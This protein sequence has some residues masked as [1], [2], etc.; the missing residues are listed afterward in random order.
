MSLIAK[1]FGSSK[2]KKAPSPQEAIQ[3]LREI[4]EMLNKKNEYLEKK[5][6]EELHT[7]KKNAAKNKRVAIQ[8]LKRKKRYEKQQQ[9]IDGT[10]TTIEFQRE[11]LENA[12]T[13]VE[14]LNVMGQAA[15]ALK[16][17]HGQMNVDQVHDL[18][19]DIHEQQEIASEIS[20]AISNP[21]GFNN[22][23]DEDDLMKELEDLEQEGLDE[24]LLDVGPSATDKLPSVPTTE[25]V[26]KKTQAKVKEDDDDMREL[27]AW[28]N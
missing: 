4:E 8:A 6:D 17:S 3:R 25:P 12:S 27:E 7:A 26:A 24:Q 21:V 2:D 14:V 13:N 11:A 19:D 18:M 28:A 23:V 1:L 16:S 10:L 15:K 9:Q 20:E 5:I 22:D